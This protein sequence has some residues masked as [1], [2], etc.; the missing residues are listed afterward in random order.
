M[1]IGK[2][3]DFTIYEEQFQT[4]YVETDQQN[5]DALVQGSNGAITVTGKELRGQY[6]QAAFFQNI[7]TSSLIIRRDLTAVTSATDLAVTQGEAISV[8]CHR[9]IGPI[10]QT[11][12]S[13]KMIGMNPNEISLVFGQQ[14]A[15]AVL[16]EKLNTSLG[17]AVGALY[18]E[19]S[20]V[21]YDA[22]NQTT[23]TITT[24]YLAAALAKFGDQASKI[25]AWVM[26]SK[27]YYDLVQ[28]QIAANVTNVA[29]IVIKGATP[30][31]LGRPVIVTDS[32]S[33]INTVATPD[34][35]VTLGL[36]ENAI[37]ITDSETPQIEGQMVTGLLQLVYRI[38]GEY[39]YNLGL[40]GFTWDTSTGGANPTA[41]AVATGVNWDPVAA[42][43]KDM[44]GVRLLTT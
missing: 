19:G 24:S 4:G 32:A 25:V 44:L 42:S 18:H 36:T 40:K 34:H 26:H 7:A 13:W 5:V 17:G 11:V 12:G 43:N 21:T 8:K 27:V 39:A 33:L 9:T 10:A 37:Q 38:Q 1:A 14:S 23:T 31:T 41:A 28:Q 6:A 2:S 16:V 35:Y 20:D 29:D 30:P 3:S 22:T 15:K